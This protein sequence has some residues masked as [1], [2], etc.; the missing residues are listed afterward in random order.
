MVHHKIF[1]AMLLIQILLA[2]AL[3]SIFVKSTSMFL[4][5]LCLG[6]ACQRAIHYSVISYVVYTSLE[7]IITK[8][9]IEDYKGRTPEYVIQ[10]RK[11]EPI[12]IKKYNIDLEEYEDLSKS[13]DRNEMKFNSRKQEQSTRSKLNLFEK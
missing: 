13:K 11:S 1:Q 10:E 7:P 12:F 2:I 8:V 9:S 6:I 3:C 5:Y 4:F